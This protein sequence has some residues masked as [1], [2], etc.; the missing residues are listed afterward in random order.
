VPVRFHPAASIFPLVQGDEFAALVADT[1]DLGQREPITLHPDGSILDGRNRYRACQRIGIEPK[2]R[3]WNG[4]GSALE[5]VL[6][7]NLHRRHLS[8][9]QRAAL[10]VDLLPRFEAEARERQRGGRGGILLPGLIPEA[11]GESRE[12]VGSHH[13]C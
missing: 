7:L 4:R 5:F 2:F 11:K 3:T 13:A 6:S 8:A 10:A 1:R 12:K 9:S